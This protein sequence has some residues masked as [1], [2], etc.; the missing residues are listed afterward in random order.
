MFWFLSRPVSF[1]SKDAVARTPFIGMF[2]I[3][4]QSLFLDRSDKDQRDKIMDLIKGRAELGHQGLLPQL[5]IFPEGTVSNGSSLLKFKKGAFCHT[6]PIKVYGVK[7]N[8]RFVPSLSNAT[9]GVA[10]FLTLCQFW[11]TLDF[12]EINENFDPL[13]V[14]NKYRLN[15]KTDPDAWEKVADELKEVMSVM[16]GIPKVEDGFRDIQ[17]MEKIQADAYAKI[18]LCCD[19]KEIPTPEDGEYQRLVNNNR[20]E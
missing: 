7:Y 10:V 18:L 12:Y 17:K 5:L 6:K 9:G 2:A 14:Y 4:R 13:F 8:G 16:M 19:G 3:A 15:P 20:N 1:L 11:N